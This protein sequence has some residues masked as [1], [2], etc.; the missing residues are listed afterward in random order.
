MV[1]K[2]VKELNQKQ[3]QAVIYDKGPLLVL[4]GAGSGKTR[5]LTYKTSFYILEKKIVPE[6]ILLLTFTNKAAEEMKQRIKNQLTS[7]KAKGLPLAGT[8]HWLCAKILRK[9]GMKIGIPPSYLIYD[10]TDQKD[11][12]KHAM[13]LLDIPSKKFKPS[14]VASTISSAKNKLIEPKEYKNYARGF[15]KETVAKIYPLYQKLLTSYEALDFDDLI[16]KTVKLFEENNLTLKKYKNNFPYILID[17][18]HDTNHAQYKLTKLLAGKADNLTVVADCSQ[19][20]YGWRGAD[21]KNVLNLK[22]DFP[23]IK[24][25][26]LE[27]NY[28]C[29][30]TILKA[31]F[32][33]IN[34]NTSHPVLKLWTNNF[35]GDRLQVYQARSEKDEALFIV[36]KILQQ[37][38]R[39]AKF[40][41]FAVLYRTNAQS[42]VLEEA[43]LHAGLPYTL[44][45]GIRFYERKEIKD[46][47]AYLRLLQNPKDRISYKRTEKLG[48]KRLKKFL[49]L[50]EKLNIKK[51]KT[52]TI[53][54]RVLKTTDYWSRFDE[55][56]EKG[57][58]RIENIKELFSVASEFS[59]LA[60]F[61][62]NVSLVEQE[63]GVKTSNEQKNVVTLM[64]MHAAK[65]LEFNTVFITGM[66]EGLFPH[67]RSLFEKKELEEE[68]RLAYVG[69]T[70]AKQNLFLTCSYKRL[71]FGSQN[72]NQISRF[73]EEI[74]NSLLKFN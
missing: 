5:V 28:R 52:Q 47:L 24:T 41:D 3:Q 4:A 46:C 48:K 30:K 64:T 17:E 25:I 45:G 49:K 34:K 36:E 59:K 50:A 40:S 43:F 39:G 26:N 29:S 63:Y 61:L 67:S 33:V 11:L 19:S 27:Q 7:K 37:A 12:I 60:D 22:K 56:N 20:I 10:K 35:K 65:G 42:R 68:R 32:N 8:F 18:Y 15:F 72:Y 62:E 44:V 23:K 38:S 71:Y 58:V 57:L 14:S 53:L 2:L 9:D 16:L 74:D 69:I 55:N 6:N 1:F 13:G 31:A 70:R 66:E 21:F 73:I 51:N 54:K